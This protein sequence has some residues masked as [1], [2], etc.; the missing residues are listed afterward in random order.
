MKIFNRNIL[1]RLLQVILT[2]IAYGLFQAVAFRYFISFSFP[3]YMLSGMLDALYIHGLAYVMWKVV[4]YG[5]FKVLKI[6]NMLLNYFVLGTL[7]SSIWLALGIF[8]LRLLVGANYYQEIMMIS[9]TKVILAF[10]IFPL[11]LF[12]FQ[13]LL[14][15]EKNTVMLEKADEIVADELTESPME[16]EELEKIE[17]IAVKTGQKLEVITIPDIVYFQADGDYVRIVTNTSKFL[18]ED[19]IKFYQARL[20]ETQFVRVHRSYLVNIAKIMRIEQ[21][22][23]QSQLLLMSNGDKL[24]ISTSGYKRL[25]EVLGL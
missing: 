16:T 24:K 17:R 2:C 7:L 13:H 3:L 21:Y 11:I 22:G 9:Q 1:I 14:E 10:L 5:N 18:K 20:S 6:R 23:K 12:Y 19:T 8:T 15:K 4:K 25:R